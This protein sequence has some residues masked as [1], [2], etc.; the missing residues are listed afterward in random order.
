VNAIHPG[1]VK[2]TGAMR[3]GPIDIEHYAKV[4]NK[5]IF[6]PDQGLCSIKCNIS[7]ISQGSFSSV[8]AATDPS[9]ERENITGKFIDERGKIE[10]VSPQ[11]KDEELAKQVWTKS[12]EWTGFK[13]QL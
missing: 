10:D 11:A 6:D 13:Y 2:G 5:P 7:D 3:H 9:I 4:F 8:F 1:I 12:E